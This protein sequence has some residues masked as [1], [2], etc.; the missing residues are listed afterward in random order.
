MM[1]PILTELGLFLAPFALYAAFLLLTR[2]EVLLPAAWTMPRV[3]SLLIVSL[4]LVVGS[5]FLLA[6]FSG[7]PPGS[8]Y[9]PAHVVNG[10]FVPGAT[11]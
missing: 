2:A 1:R 3:A 6:Q 9:V 8:T 5:F 10:K 7:A 11:R 4:V